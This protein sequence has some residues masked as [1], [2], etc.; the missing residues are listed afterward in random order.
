M[1]LQ[2][3]LLLLLSTLITTTNAQT[4]VNKSN[5]K[6]EEVIFNVGMH[7]QSC[8]ERIEKYLPM[9]TGVKDLKVDLD[10]KEVTIVFNPQK[11]TL[12][13]LKKAVEDLG[14]TCEKK[15]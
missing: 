8:K 6:T 12:E 11:T 4:T 14:Y 15:E 13:K 7:C 9:E 3:T 10:K 2:I 1:K 5:K